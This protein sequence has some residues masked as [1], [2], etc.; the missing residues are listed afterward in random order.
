[1][2]RKQNIRFL[3]KNKL[4]SY[5]AYGQSKHADKIKTEQERRQL[6]KA[7]ASFRQTLEVNYCKDKIYSYQTMKTYQNEVNK[8]ADWL[9]KHDMKK[10]D[11]D[12]AKDYIQDYIDD[13]AKSKS[14]W[15]CNTALSAL[16]KTFQTCS[17]DYNRPIRHSYAIKRGSFAVERDSL[18][19]KR[20]LEILTANR[21]IGIRR[22]ELKNLRV[23]D[24]KEYERNGREII[25]LSY[26]GK[27]GKDCHNFYYDG[28]SQEFIRGLLAGKNPEEKVFADV[29]KQFSFDADLHSARREAAINMYH[30]I[31]D[32]PEDRDFYM[33]ELKRVFE[34]KGKALPN[35]I[36]TIYKLRGQ[37]KIEHEKM[38]LA[39]EVDRFSAL[40]VSTLLLNHYRVN[41]S[42]TN[43]LLHP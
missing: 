20:A 15:S 23:S 34:E 11:W 10:V 1:M 41:V 38:G 8:Y 7:G 26:K 33:S 18:N 17:S 42:V 4:A 39:T 43:Y 35:N 37:N 25:E 31:L 24:F 14:A 30:N 21:I 27:G 5:A 22:N 28:K 19:E 9:E 13:I 40:C 36:Y 29:I 32:H 2:A 16:C 6:K 3:M 12:T